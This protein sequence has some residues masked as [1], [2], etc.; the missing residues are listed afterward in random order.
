MVDSTEAFTMIG[1]KASLCDKSTEK[2]ANSIFTEQIQA[3]L[4][5]AAG[6]KSNRLHNKVGRTPIREAMTKVFLRKTV[7]FCVDV[8]AWEQQTRLVTEIGVSIY[9]PRGQELAMSPYIKTYHILIKENMHRKNGR[10]VPEH[11]ANFNGGLSYVLT[12]DSAID[13]MQSLIDTYFH[14]LPMPCILVGHDV[15]GDIKWLSQ[16]GIQMPT[17]VEVLDTQILYTQTHG[18]HGN[19]LKNALRDIGQPYAF[20]HNAGNDAYYTVLLALRLCDPQVRKLVNFDRT[21]GAEESEGRRINAKLDHNY[22]KAV[23]TTKDDILSGLVDLTA[24][25]KK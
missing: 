19:S 14:N 18:R 6:T 15:K 22:S 23:A 20:L 3:Y 8:E 9:D 24:I 7:L 25:V 10:F 2:S 12:K 11:S 4:D 21:S 1:V 17:N 16:L 13:L 5:E